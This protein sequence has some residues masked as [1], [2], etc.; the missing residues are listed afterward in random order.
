MSEDKNLKINF[1]L[2][3]SSLLMEGLMALG[4]TENPITK[5]TET[6][7]E[8]ASQVIDALDM[9]KENRFPAME[10]VGNRAKFKTRIDLGLHAY[11]PV[12]LCQEIDHPRDI[13]HAPSG[14]IATYAC[15][16]ATLCT[17]VLSLFACGTFSHGVYTPFKIII[18]FR[19]R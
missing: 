17:H 12:F 5:K 2:F 16:T 8:H 14:K 11:Q 7:L 10:F 9:L 18:G 1:S 13:G 4:V 15:F 19:S 6:N 3:I